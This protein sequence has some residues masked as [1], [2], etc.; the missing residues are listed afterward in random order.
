MPLAVDLVKLSANRHIQQ[1]I[2]IAGDSDFIPA[3]SAAKDE[4]VMVKLY[5][6]R[7]PH[8][9]LLEEVDEHFRIEQALVDSVRLP[10]R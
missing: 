10:D 9:E 5:H 8:R 1:A 3:I 4:G 2:L 6:G 7:R